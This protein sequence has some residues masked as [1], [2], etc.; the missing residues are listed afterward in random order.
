[1]R[2]TSNTSEETDWATL[3]FKLS[4]VT[5]LQAPNNPFEMSNFV[6]ILETDMD[7]GVFFRAGQ[8]ST[9]VRNIL[10]HYTGQPRILLFLAHTS[11]SKFEIDLDKQHPTLNN[12][13]LFSSDSAH[14]TLQS[15]SGRSW[16]RAFTD[17]ANT[18]S[19]FTNVIMINNR[20][21]HKEGIDQAT[22]PL[23]K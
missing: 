5:I 4:D 2:L 8:S 9:H 21:H 18:V 16:C 11:S 15:C 17:K 10:V 14:D 1:M 19:S 3:N 22:T 20:V 23:R 13:V 12:I 6:L 7:D